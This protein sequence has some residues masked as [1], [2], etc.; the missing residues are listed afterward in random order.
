M[1]ASAEHLI[2]DYILFT[3]EFYVFI[4]KSLFPV[5]KSGLPR[6]YSGL[7]REEMKSWADA[8]ATTVLGG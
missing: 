5:Y 8:M 4:L 2:T 7:L 6:Y 3:S 1:A